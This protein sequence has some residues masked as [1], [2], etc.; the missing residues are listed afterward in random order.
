M[1]ASGCLFQE[2]QTGSE[3]D[4]PTRV[5]FSTYALLTKTTSLKLRILEWS[6]IL[7]RNVFNVI[8]ITLSDK[9]IRFG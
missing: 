2:I 1:L 5:L 6:F 3:V 8:F 4:G 9:I 7:S